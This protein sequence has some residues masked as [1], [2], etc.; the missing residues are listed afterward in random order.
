MSKSATAII[1]LYARICNRFL[2]IF[3]VNF[4]IRGEFVT[5]HGKFSEPVAAR[6]GEN[7]RAAERETAIASATVRNAALTVVMTRA[8]IT[9]GRD[10]ACGELSPPLCGWP[11]TS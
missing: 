2:C 3:R 8:I 1:L 6:K 7:G 9:T 11:P 10:D 5:M 4:S